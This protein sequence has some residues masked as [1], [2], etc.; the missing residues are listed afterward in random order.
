M[1]DH[2]VYT[3]PNHRPPKMD[4]LVKAFLK[5]ILAA[6][7]LVWHSST[8][9]NSIDDLCLLLCLLLLLCVVLFYQNLL[10]YGHGCGSGSSSH[11]VVIKSLFFVFVLIKICVYSVSDPDQHLFFRIWI[12]IKQRQIQNTGFKVDW[13]RSRSLFGGSGSRLRL[14]A[15]SG[16]AAQTSLQKRVPPAPQH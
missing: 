4:V 2:P 15:V 7:R 5:I 9:R 13:M 1:D 3:T 14:M 12:R 10:T 6:K 11:T 16:A 8:C